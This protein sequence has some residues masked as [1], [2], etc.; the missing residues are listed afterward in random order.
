MDGGSYFT[1]F[2]ETMSTY[3]LRTMKQSNRK[4]KISHLGLPQSNHEDHPPSKHIQ[5]QHIHRS[6]QL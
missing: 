3:R 1:Y 5:K 2:L 6:K 4:T